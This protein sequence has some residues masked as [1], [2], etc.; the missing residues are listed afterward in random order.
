MKRVGCAGGD[1]LSTQ[2]GQTHIVDGGV[3]LNL[4]RGGKRPATA[5]SSLVL[6]VSDHP[7]LP[8][9]N[10][11][12]QVRNLRWIIS[13]TRIALLLLWITNQ[14]PPY[15]PLSIHWCS[16][17]SLTQNSI[18]ELLFS[19]I[20]KLCHS[21]FPCFSWSIVVLLDLLQIAKKYVEPKTIP[22]LDLF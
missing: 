19:Q 22:F 9:V 10:M 20:S 7:S 11:V 14:N 17:I 5:T 8:P 12:W 21:H 6:G 16:D 1:L 3:A 15:S 4:F 13:K 18:P 2:L